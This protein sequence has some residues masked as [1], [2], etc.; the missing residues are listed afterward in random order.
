MPIR[1]DPLITGEYYHVYNRTY[2]FSPFQDTR[3]CDRAIFCFWYSNIP[4]SLSVS[5]YLSSSNFIQENF[6]KQIAIFNPK[7]TIISFCLMPNHFHLLLR[8][9][10][11]GGISKFVSDLQNCIT[12]FFNRKNKCKGPL[13]ERQFK[14]SHI[15]NL[16]LLLH[17]SRYI[18]LNPFSAYL[19]RNSEDLI[20]YPYSSLSYYMDPLLDTHNIINR[21]LIIPHFKNT[22]EYLKFIMDHAE[23]QRSI[24]NLRYEYIDSDC[25]PSEG[26]LWR[27]SE[28]QLYR[29]ITP[30]H[31]PWIFTLVA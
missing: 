31:L 23:H 8:Q 6:V 20:K 10:I 15:K 22:D 2:R 11:D 30:T 16:E 29:R 13:F 12:L 28:G 9:E 21:N 1:T 27:P 26:I 5:D 3:L 18:H 14:T 24:S 7:V 17:V 4:H 25:W 19:M